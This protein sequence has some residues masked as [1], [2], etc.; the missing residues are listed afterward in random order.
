M[1]FYLAQGSLWLISKALSKNCPSSSPNWHLTRQVYNLMACSMVLFFKHYPTLRK[2]GLES[3]QVKVHIKYYKEA[4][5][6]L[7]SITIPPFSRRSAYHINC[8][9]KTS[10]RLSNGNFNHCSSLN[11]CT[12]YTKYIGVKNEFDTESCENKLNFHEL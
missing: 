4:L 2:W 5:L 8:I 1:W 9:E 7:I 11:D 6:L 3:H 12:G 10:N